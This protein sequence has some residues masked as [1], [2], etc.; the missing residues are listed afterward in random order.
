[1]TDKNGTIKWLVRLLVDIAVL[2]LVVAAAWG[3]Y[4]TKVSRAEQDISRECTERIETDKELIIKVDGHDRLITRIDTKL[5]N[6]Q[7][8]LEKI[9]N[10]L[11]K[12]P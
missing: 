12:I 1:M 5:E 2:L 3:M 9:E 6:M 11:D 8:T 4:G 7:K 10:K